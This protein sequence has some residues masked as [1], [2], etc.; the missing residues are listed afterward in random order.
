MPV[1]L[2]LSQFT[3]LNSEDNGH[4]QVPRNEAKFNRNKSL[5]KSIMSWIM[6]LIDESSSPPAVLIT[7][8]ASI[9]DE[10]WKVCT[11][12][13]YLFFCSLQGAKDGHRFSFFGNESLEKLLQQ[14][15]IYIILDHKSK[16]GFPTIL[17]ES[18]SVYMIALL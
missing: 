8:R 16:G 5:T 14:E 4:P 12:F 18:S 3:E 2:K 13:I 6:F 15:E 1:H 7:S 11:Y 17:G 10:S 9:E